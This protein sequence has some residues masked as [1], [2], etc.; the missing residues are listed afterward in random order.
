MGQYIRS[1]TEMS[2][3]REKC[4]HSLNGTELALAE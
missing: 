4:H 3:G 2:I 1:K